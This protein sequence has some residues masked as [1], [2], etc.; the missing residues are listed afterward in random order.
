MLT[1]KINANKTLH[2]FV[3]NTNGVGA[4]FSLDSAWNLSQGAGAVL[5]T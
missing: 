3:N 4:C 5:P 1:D 2:K